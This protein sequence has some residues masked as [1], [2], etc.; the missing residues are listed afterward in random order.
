MSK[1]LEAFENIKDEML[2]W[3]EGYEEDLD[4]VEKEL[5][6]KE[7][8][9]NLIKIIKETI[10]FGIKDNKVEVS[11]EGDVSIIGTIGLILQKELTEKEKTLFR[12]WIL[13]TCF[14]KELKALEI[15]KNK[16]INIDYF[17]FT[18]VKNDWSYE[19]YL[20]EVSDVNSIALSGQYNF[21][22]HEPILT[23]EEYDLLKEVLL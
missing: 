13:E 20:D 18:C 23:K 8:Q 9:D 6:E 11:K 17:I 22:E 14:P 12:D 4:I 2:E 5:E 10:E 15:I 1:G 19:G 3:T 21:P 7:Q 16:C